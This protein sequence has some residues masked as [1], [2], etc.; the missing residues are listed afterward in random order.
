MIN[1]PLSFTKIDLDSGYYININYVNNNSVKWYIHSYE[2]VIQVLNQLQE[3]TKWF[4]QQTEAPLWLTSGITYFLDEDTHVLFKMYKSN[5]KFC[6]II[7]QVLVEYISNEKEYYQAT[8]DLSYE[9]EP[10]DINEKVKSLTRTPSYQNA[11]D[12]LYSFF[13]DNQNALDGLYSLGIDT[14]QTL[15]E[16]EKPSAKQV[17]DQQKEKYNTMSLFGHNLASL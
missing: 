1:L 8:V 3:Y 11:L 9:I 5:N 15:K 17:F 13:I 16:S 7:P 4:T 10:T 14:Q 12:E 2:L 6:E